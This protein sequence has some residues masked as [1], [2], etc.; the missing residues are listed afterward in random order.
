VN[1]SP[2]AFIDAATARRPTSRNFGISWSSLRKALTVWP[3]RTDGKDEPI[4]KDW[5]SARALLSKVRNA[6]AQMLK[7]SR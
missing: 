4:L 2:I 1:F 3:L 7:G 5:K 6:P